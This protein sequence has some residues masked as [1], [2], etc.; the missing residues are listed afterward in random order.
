MPKLLTCPEIARRSGYSRMHIARL[1]QKNALPGERIL[2]AGGQYRYECAPKMVRWMRLMRTRRSSDQMRDSCFIVRKYYSRSTAAVV[3]DRGVALW[4]I[5]C[6]LEEIDE[7][8]LEVLEGGP[9]PTRQEYDTLLRCLGP[10]IAGLTKCHETI[11]KA[12]GA[13]APTPQPKGQ[14]KRTAPSQPVTAGKS[15]TTRAPVPE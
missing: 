1:A 2:T 15:K 10:A 7:R 3:G 6:L 8:I 11:A 9:E 4:E 14:A 13:P 5:T 12:M